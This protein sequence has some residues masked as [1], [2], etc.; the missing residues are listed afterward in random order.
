MNLLLKNCLVV[1]EE[2]MEGTLS[3]L[4]IR[5]DRIV[6]EKD[7]TEKEIDYVVDLKGKRVM[8]GLVDFHTHLYQGGS[9]FGLNPDMLFSTGVTT[10]VDMG[11]AG[12][13][14]FDAF[15]QTN[16]VPRQMRLKAFLNISPIGQ[17][18]AGLVEPLNAECFLP[19]E[20]EKVIAKHK[21]VIAGLKV[22]VSTNLVGDLGLKP[23]EDAVKLGE[24]FNLPVCVH[25]T[26]PPS[27]TEDIA[28]MLR[29]RDIYS[30]TYQGKGH[31]II[32]ED[33]KVL[34]ALKEAQKRGVLF[35][36]GQGRYNLD[37]KVVE[38]A[39][40]DGFFP[41]IIST[42]ATPRTIFITEH[43]RNMPN[44]MSKFLNLGMAWK[45]V[46][47][48]SVTTPAKVIGLEKEV[49]TLAPGTAADL[50]AFDFVEKEGKKILVPRVTIAQG[51]MVYCQTDF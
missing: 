18:G 26:N 22:R 38:A 19:E 32:G 25:T 40:A 2:N 14:N 9:G 37:D 48:A 36:V 50:V 4:A 34:P 47:R 15:Y 21:V 46:F 44:M 28:R 23:L 27:S 16:I 30:H 6:E 33:G 49:S 7:L 42:D 51:N 43:M 3:N 20:M 41:D 31:T 10:A 5:G 45:D 8:P 1:T 11:T 12:R 29:P 35:E 13:A 17:P 24:K 39:L